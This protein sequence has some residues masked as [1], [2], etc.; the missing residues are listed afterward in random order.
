MFADQKSD[1]IDRCGLENYSAKDLDMDT[2]RSYR[3]RMSSANPEH[4]FLSFDDLEFLK[5]LHVFQI[6]RQTEN[7]ELTVADLLMFGK[8]SSIL[9]E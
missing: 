4:P 7:E 3:N 2:V 5:K 6:N 1:G 9:K 8:Y